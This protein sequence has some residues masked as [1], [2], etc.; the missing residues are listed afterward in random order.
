MGKYFV[1]LFLI[2]ASCAPKSSASGE[3]PERERAG[4]KYDKLNAKA[5]KARQHYLEVVNKKGSGKKL[6]KA[7]LKMRKAEAQ[8]EKFKNGMVPDT[9]H[10]HNTN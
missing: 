9:R 7:S 5:L 6:E 3:N 1:F 8:L 4:K 2:I 10:R